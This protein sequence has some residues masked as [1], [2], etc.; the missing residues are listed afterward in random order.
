MQHGPKDDEQY[1]QTHFAVG[2]VVYGVGERF[3]SELYAYARFISSESN[4]MWLSAHL[5]M[6]GSDA[7]KAEYKNH[8]TSNKPYDHPILLSK[9]QS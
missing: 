1:H 7:V 4:T 9:S 8:Q 3:V 6:D 5:H 2:R